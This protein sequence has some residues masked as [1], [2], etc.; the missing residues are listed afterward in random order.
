MATAGNAQTASAVLM[1][2]PTAFASN[3]Q[4]LASNAFQQPATDTDGV[5]AVA[6]QEFDALAAALSSHGVRVVCFEGRSEHDSPDECFPNNWLSLHAD[7]TVVL[8]PMMAENRRCERR[9]D[10]VAAL[11]DNYGYDI[12][13]FVDLSHHE[14]HARYLEGTGSVVL[15]HIDRVAFACISPRTHTHVLDDFSKQLG[16][17]VVPFDAATHNGT[18]IYH[19]N[20][21]LSIGQDFSIVCSEAITDPAMRSTV[22]E[23]LGSSER[24]TIDVSL[25]QVHAFA[26]NI[27]EL[28][29]TES[30]L[31][32]LSAGALASLTVEQQGRLETHG[33]LVSVALPTLETYGGG[34][35]RCLLA[36]IF[37][38][39]ASEHRL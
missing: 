6:L 37:L 14:L 39:N 13:R 33:R 12:S 21:M 27:L 34:G 1:V 36:E 7:G 29:G 20:V 5:M 8:Y 28:Q 3:P 16:Y 9:P 30:P 32:A 10:F 4:T 11:S 19:T 22:L 18:A 15:D 38:P 35:L 31:I 2:R 26:A 24:E 23:R 17:E 25:E